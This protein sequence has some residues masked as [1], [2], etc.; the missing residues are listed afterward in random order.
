MA[1]AIGALTSEANSRSARAR[2]EPIVS[3]V[4]NVR[5]VVNELQTRG[6]K[7]NFIELSCSFNG[8]IFALPL[9]L[10]ERS[11]GFCFGQLLA[12][13][14]AHQLGFIVASIMLRAAARNP[15]VG[16]RVDGIATDLAKKEDR[17]RTQKG[18]NRFGGQEPHV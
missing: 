8:N 17:L 7:G 4:T 3:S 10:R 13:V 14:L 5:Q 1:S 18:Q 9:A 2:A 16:Q 12:Q 6:Q 11:H 15:C